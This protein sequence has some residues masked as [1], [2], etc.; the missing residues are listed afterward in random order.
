MGQRSNPVEVLAEGLAHPEGGDV[1]PDGR[2][3]FVETFQGR[4]SAW[5]PEEGV[6]PYA[7]FGGGPNS[8]AVGTDGVYITQT[9]G[10]IGGWRA[11]EVTA[12]SIQKRAS[13]REVETLVTSVDGAPLICPNDLAFGREGQLYF[14]DPGQ[15]NPDEPEEGRI[16][17]LEPD[18]SASVV[19]E[20][21]PTYPN[22]LACHSDGS[23]VWSESY[24]R[25]IR[26][27]KPNG[28]IELL[29]TLPEDRIVDGLKFA[30]NGDL[31]ITGITSAGV[32]VLSPG[33][34]VDGFIHTGGEPQNCVFKGDA[35][36]IADFGL[37]PQFGPDGMRAAA[38]EGRL[39]RVPT[40]V[41]GAPMFHGSI[42][43]PGSGRAAA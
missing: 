27:R 4:V 7:E 12:P 10:E 3:V 29:A 18:G 16:C 33:G 38:E 6:R 39:L 30:E 35:L 34:E 20:P 1:L 5:G 9:G 15:W 25:T 42:E 21:G 26:R 23:F 8:C 19:V 2:V 37:I 36:Y 11:P 14:T 41:G 40:E 43:P 24:T 28:E 32:D 17:V 13:G 31:Y 22:G